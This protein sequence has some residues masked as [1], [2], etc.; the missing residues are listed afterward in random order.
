MEMIEIRTRSREE[1]VDLTAEIARIVGASGVAEGACVV[2]VPH[3]TAAV[4]IN[5]NADPD[6]KTDILMALRKAVPD[7]L[8]YEHAVLRLYAERFLLEVPEDHPSFVEAYRL[9]RFIS[10]FVPIFDETIPQI[11]ILREFIGESFFSY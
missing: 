7:S 4:T 2:F 6:V 10:Y 11:S 1:I 3:T 8:P 5:E 9:L